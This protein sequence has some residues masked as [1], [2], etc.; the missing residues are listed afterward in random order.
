MKNI[1]K[2]VSHIVSTIWNYA[3]SLCDM[4]SVLLYVSTIF[5]HGL[6]IAANTH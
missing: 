2:F 3:L 4:Y 1:V 5:P 6:V